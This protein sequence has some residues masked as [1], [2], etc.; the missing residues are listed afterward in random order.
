MFG[1][2]VKQTARGRPHHNG[3]CTPGCPSSLQ[4]HQTVLIRN[5]GPVQATGYL[6][7]HIGLQQ[8][9]LFTV[10]GSAIAL[11]F[12]ACYPESLPASKRKQWSW[13]AANVIFQ[14]K[15]QLSYRQCPV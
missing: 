4:L 2:V 1:P 7:A 14:H 9:F 5:R 12:A 3:H 11:G 8:S 15:V 6:A 10:V 13:S